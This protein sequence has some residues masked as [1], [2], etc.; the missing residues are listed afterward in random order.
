MMTKRRVI[1][2]IFVC[3]GCCCG[4]AEKGN[5]PVPRDYLKAEFKRR[6]LISKVQLTI[7]GC[8]GPCDVYNVVALWLPEGL[9]WFGGLT[10]FWQYES[11]M[12][13]AS[14]CA[15]QGEASPL[16]RWLLAHEFQVMRE[17]VL[18][19]AAS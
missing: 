16:P 12:E 3:D 19:M 17:P 5:P 10:E 4:R 14:E 11:L 15:D 2:Q 13:W 6:K 7:T 8:L 1:A 9:R 18:E